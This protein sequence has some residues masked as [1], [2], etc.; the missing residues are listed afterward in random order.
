MPRIGAMGVGW[1]QLRVVLFLGL[2]VQ[3]GASEAL[4][5]LSDESLPAALETHSLMLIT[6]SVPDCEPCDMVA[7]KFKAALKELRVKAPSVVLA[8]LTLTSQDSPNIGAIVQGQMTIPKVLIFREGEAMDYEGELTKPSIVEVMLREF[9]RPTVQQLKSVKQAERFLH[10]DTWSA[11]HSDEEKPPR[12]VGFFPSNETAG[13]AIFRS[14]AKKLQ[15]MIAFG[16]CFDPMLQKKFLGSAAKKSVIQLVKADKR[17]RKLTYSGVLAVPPLARWIATH[18]L[19]IVQDLTT[20]SSIEAHM[21]RG[22]PVF[23]LLMPDEYEESLSDIIVHLRKVAQ[24]VRERLLFA[25]GF[26]DTEPWPQFA[27]SL[28]IPRDGTGA[29]WMIVGN[30]MDITGRDWSMAWLRPPSLGFQIYAM[31]ARGDEDASDVT[32]KKLSKFVKGFLDKVDKVLPPEQYEG[33][34]EEDISDAGSRS[35][36]SGDATTAAVKEE[37]T[38]TVSY[39]KELRKLIGAMEMNFNSGVANL[40]KALDDLKDTPQL[41]PGKSPG[42]VSTL[43]NTEL[44]L[45]KDVLGLKRKL[46][47]IGKSKDEL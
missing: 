35:S 31:E 28:G 24:S 44:K 23:L 25:Y 42:L 2:A 47:D 16:E 11:Q 20:E 3:A 34:V 26:K 30:G 36:T 32:E 21:A 9:S 8:R 13:Y 29:F 41:L 15:G 17:E 14:T 7:R 18:S 22:V 33:V 4:L 37:G 38:P 40:K 10:L 27:Q 5:E 1:P 39:D 19:A 43:S 12:V 46:M 45:K 6:V